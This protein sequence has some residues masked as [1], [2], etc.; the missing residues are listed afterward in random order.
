MYEDGYRPRFHTRRLKLCPNSWRLRRQDPYDL[1]Q[2]GMEHHD[3]QA[4]SQ[5]QSYA[6]HCKLHRRI[7]VFE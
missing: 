1:R 4:I 5:V 7:L 3:R 6:M 2:R